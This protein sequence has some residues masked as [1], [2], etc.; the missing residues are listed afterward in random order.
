M[1]HELVRPIDQDTAHAIAEAAKLGRDLLATA[2]K[3][4]TY[5]AVVFGPLTA[6]SVGLVV[7]GSFISVFAV[8]QQ[9]G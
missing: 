1:K 7:I 3:A 6:Q 2:N 5:T 9:Y 8:L 4:G